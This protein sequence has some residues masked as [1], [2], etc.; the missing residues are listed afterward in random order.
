M[1]DEN[2]LY[3]EEVE[4][5]ILGC[6]LVFEDCIRYVKE[7]ETDE[8]YTVLHRKIFEIIKELEEK[9]NPVDLLSVKEIGKVKGLDDKKLL[10]YLAKITSEVVT[11]ASI[12]YYISKLKNYATRRKI[13]K[14]SQK[15]V[16]NMYEI[17]SDI[18]AE[19][20][21]KDAMQAISDIKVNSKSNDEE[22]EMKNVIAESMR[23]IENKY[24]K[25]DD[26][27]YHTGLF[28]LDKVTDGL[29]EQELTLIAARPRSRKDS[30]S[31]KNS[32]EYIS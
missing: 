23:D 17:N 3:S 26:Y 30:I 14:A 24:H 6:M 4:Q 2:K 31:F 32:R 25:R 16:S 13:I 5:N 18:E 8:F 10:S 29:H 22:N 27:K 9:D 21:K 20:I 28:E 15:I 1:Q 11:S 7:I 12:E 19:E